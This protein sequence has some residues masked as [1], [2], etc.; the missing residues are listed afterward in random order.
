[1]SSELFD[2]AVRRNLRVLVES[3]VMGERLFGIAER[4]ARTQHDR[5]IWQALHALEEQT[6]DAVFTRLG[7]DI[8][9]FT[10]AARVGDISGL[11]SGT[12]MSITPRGVQFRSLVL[13]TRPF[14]RHFRRLDDHFD[15]TSHGAFFRYVLAHEYAIAEVGRRA[16]MDADDA[17]APVESLLGKV[18]R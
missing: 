3:E 9:R 6:R 5:R 16:L 1:M 7:A 2:P 12:G 18:P 15:G 10:R 13:G 4:H 8:E 11:A 14:V 17:V